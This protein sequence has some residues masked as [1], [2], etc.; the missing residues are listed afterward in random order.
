MSEN[1]GNKTP[2]TYVKTDMESEEEEKEEKTKDARIAT[3]IGTKIKFGTANSK[4]MVPNPKKNKGSTTP[5]SH[6]SKYKQ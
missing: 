1:K 4:I 3:K 2:S 5:T 6:P